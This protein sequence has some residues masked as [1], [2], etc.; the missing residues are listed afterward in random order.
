MQNI[1]LIAMMFGLLAIGFTE[2][3]WG[4]QRIP[5]IQAVLAG[6]E[7]RMA[8]VRLEVPAVTQDGSSVPV[9]V[10]VD[11][12]MRADAYV[13]AIH[14]FAT[15]N[16][17]PELAEYTLHPLLGRASLSTRI[18]LDQSQAV[19]ALARTSDG[20]WLGA[21]ESVR[22]TVSGCL[23]RAGTYTSD[24]HMQVRVRVPDRLRTGQVGEVRT[25]I[26][27]PMETGLREDASGRVIPANIIE[28][29]HVKWDDQ[30]VLRARWHRAMAANPYLLFSI[31]PA[32]S[33]ALSMRWT[34][35]TGATAEY[36][37]AI[38]VRP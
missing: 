13:E 38:E 32:Q 34:E 30:P 17:S 16:P 18:R 26:Q 7:P 1:R 5:E 20:E 29:L 25:M 3:V 28:E 2:P 24:N 35:D 27:H 31:A 4:W 33:G 8:G 19:V 6:T 22:V 11:A 12:P 9:T 23:S 21:V 15:R 37:A 14:L 10:T 36:R